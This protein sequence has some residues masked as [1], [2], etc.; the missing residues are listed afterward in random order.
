MKK[1]IPKFLHKALKDTIGK[2]KTI[3]FGKEDILN[4]EYIFEK[5]WDERHTVMRRVTFQ[6]RETHPL[7]TLLHNNDS[8]DEFVEALESG[9]NDEA[10]QIADR[11]I[12]DYEDYF[13]DS[14]YDYG[15]R[16]DEEDYD[17]E[18][19]ETIDS[20][21]NIYMRGDDQPIEIQAVWQDYLPTIQQNWY[22]NPFRWIFGL[23]HT[24]LSEPSEI[25]WIERQQS[26]N[27]EDS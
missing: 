4:T 5:Q 26:R 15:E 21:N 20:E 10:S 23:K 11:A 22:I 8:F 17:E 12:V 1:T 2:V 7:H 9:D 18:Y 6:A 24:P 27:Q 13:N 25:R 19:D 16:V 3:M 14:A